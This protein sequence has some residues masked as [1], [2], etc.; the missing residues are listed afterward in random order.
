MLTKTQIANDALALLSATSISSIDDD[1]SVSGRVIKSVFD[2][3]AQKVIRSHRWSC[4]I[5][6]AALSRLDETPIQTNT[7]GYPNAFAL[8]VDCLRFLDLN[9]EPYKDKTEFLDLNG[10]KIFTHEGT[11]NI[12][13]VAWVEDTN[14]WDVLLAEAVSIRLA[15][16]SARRITKDGMSSADLNSL[17]LQA[18]DE[19][20]R[21][22]AVEVGSGENS[23]LGRMLERSPL[24]REGRRGGSLGQRLGLNINSEISR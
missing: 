14:Q 9:G 4:C 3:V 15:Q 13:Y 17:Y 5:K 10:R 1:S 12:R 16:R 23:P 6:R 7:F 22:D 18:L 24:V 21:V 8:P 19:A 11:A 20:R 2:S